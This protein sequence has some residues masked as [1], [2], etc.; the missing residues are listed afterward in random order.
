MFAAHAAAARSSGRRVLACSASRPSGLARPRRDVSE[1]SPSSPAP[2]PGWARAFSS[3]EETV[4]VPVDE[5]DPSSLADAYNR[6]R[7]VYNRSVSALR[8]QYHA[9][10][11]EQRERESRAKARE[12]A[13]VKRAALERKRLKAMRTAENARAEVE[14]RRERHARWTA[15][16]EATQRERDAKKDLTGGPGRGSS[17]SSRPSATSG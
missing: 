17:T 1:T 11:V 7:A 2:L 14:R 6:R 9:E 16:L 12:T 4:E 8:K 13:K 15:E 10:F 3:S 5:L